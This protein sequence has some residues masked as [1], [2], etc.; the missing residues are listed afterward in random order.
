M[1]A[2]AGLDGLVRNIGIMSRNNSVLSSML[3]HLTA[4]DEPTEPRELRVLLQDTGL[5]ARETG[6]LLLSLQQSVGQES[7]PSADRQRSMLNKLN[8]DFQFVLKRFQQLAEQSAQ[9]A[10]TAM[11]ERERMISQVET[12]VNEVKEI[13]SD[14]AVL[15]SN[16]SESIE[17]ISSAIEN[18][19]QKTRRANEELL[20][21][22]RYQAQARKRKCCLYAAGLAGLIILLMVLF[23]NF[24]L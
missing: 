22:N 9:H 15:I 16:Q 23:V 13:F 5:I 8:K 1:P 6:E 20:D 18:T 2:Y 7:G 10:R 14:L 21:A 19:A 24:R 11:A 17:H 12:T 4:G 3:S